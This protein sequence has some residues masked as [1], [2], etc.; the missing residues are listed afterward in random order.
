MGI[1]V[2]LI[3][4]HMWVCLQNSVQGPCLN[5]LNKKDG[6]V[7]QTESL[8]LNVNSL[9]VSCWFLVASGSGNV[10]CHRGTLTII[11]YL[12]TLIP[13]SLPATKSGWHAVLWN[14]MRN[15]AV[16]CIKHFLL[17]SLLL[18]TEWLTGG[19][20]LHITIQKEKRNQEK[21]LEQSFFPS[22]IIMFPHTVSL[23]KPM[24]S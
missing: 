6:Y 14:I 21:W 1:C 12:A 23:F 24:L 19:F 15:A 17:N 2:C 22:S 8:C 20:W 11:S 5:M 10:E 4:M 18:S 7:A 13:T 9:W 16:Y 3:C